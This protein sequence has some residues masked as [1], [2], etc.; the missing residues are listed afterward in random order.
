MLV[1]WAVG[2]GGG[3]GVL[4]AIVQ[5]GGGWSVQVVED[6]LRV[7]VWAVRGEGGVHVRICELEKCIRSQCS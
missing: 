4:E 6:L 7:L 3:V 5:V 2:G 1:E